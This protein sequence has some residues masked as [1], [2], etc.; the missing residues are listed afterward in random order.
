MNYWKGNYREINA[1]LEKIDWTWTFEGRSV[2]EMWTL[3]SKAV[4]E[5][6]ALHVPVKEQRRKKKGKWL[7]R[8]TIKRM[9]QRDEA[10]RK[11]RKYSSGKNYE[12]YRKIRNDVN[13]L[14]RQDEDMDRKQILHNFK[15]KPKSFY[16][17]MRGMQTVKENVTVLKK[18]DGEMTST[19]QEA[20]DLLGQYF[21]EVFTKESSVDVPRSSGGGPQWKDED[22]DFSVEEV[23]RKLQ[24]LIPDKSPGPDGIHPLLL[25]EC[26]STVAAPLSA[27][28]TKSYATGELPA[29]WK[30]AN[31]VPIF[32]KGSKTDRTNYRPVSLT[33]VPCK[34]MESLIK[35]KLVSFLED[36]DVITQSQHGFMAGR[37]CL[38]NLLESLESWTKAL[39]EGY[40]IDI[41][42][43]DYRKAF[44]S[45][46]KR[47]LLE[48]LRSHGISGKL[49]DWI[50]S[51]LTGR[52]M[53]VGVRGTYSGWLDV[54][55]GVPQ[56]SVLGPL[57]FL[58]FVNELPSWIVTNMKMFAD[59]TKLWN[60]VNSV[61]DGQKL[62][63]DLD[64]LMDWSDKW[65]LKFNAAKCK[66]MHVGHSLDTRY[67]IRDETGPVQLQSVDEER[68][69]GVFFTKDL[70][71]STQCV[72]SAAKARRIIGMVRRNF[73][74]LDKEDFLLIYKTYIRPHLEYCVQSWSPHLVK[75]MECLERVQ[76]TAT[77][78]VP[79]L[80]KFSYEERLKRL[81]LTT[82]RIRRTR[83]DLIEV[84]KIMTGRERINKDQLFHT[85]QN[86]HGLRGHSLKIVKE[87]STRDVRKYFFT[88]RVVND[89]NKL[90]QHVVDA[91]TVNG[92][93]NALDEYWKDMDIISSIA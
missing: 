1:A 35:D 82:L 84:F 10:W 2:E 67:F 47:R 63:G 38:T 85:S 56:G 51:F 17:Y 83:G 79:A 58:L 75:D 70:K 73:R 19:D 33:S 69:L 61:A 72:R 81:G 44:D 52:T 24:R 43:L 34:I 46:P 40:G 7:S 53:R 71:S 77:N 78:L 87:R 37:S 91:K 28:Y 9:K 92:F 20:A 48:R 64:R 42:Y 29:E 49:L 76:R 22:V 39:D 74:R 27:I 65:L 13:R 21:K 5:Q 66:V 8:E 57:L 3:F 18:D 31:V 30:T 25:K 16:G 86:S 23:Q 60:K 62:Q 4:L 32:K 11:Y 55:S 45:V 26:A 90:P 14:V 15:G 89:W 6:V 36:N 80:K 59:D 54:I 93:K 41:I 88:Q 12:E 50:E 68:D